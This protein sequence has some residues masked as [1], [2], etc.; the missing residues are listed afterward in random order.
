MTPPGTAVPGYD[1]VLG[2]PAVPIF[3]S[4]VLVNKIGDRHRGAPR[5]RRSGCVDGAPRLSHNSQ[6]SRES[7]GRSE[8]IRYDVFQTVLRVFLI[9]ESLL[10]YLLGYSARRVPVPPPST[11]F[12]TRVI[13]RRPELASFFFKKKRGAS[14]VRSLRIRNWWTIH[15]GRAVWAGHGGA[16]RGGHGGVGGAGRGYHRTVEG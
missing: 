10:K 16:R 7:C 1:V 11:K 4:F 6:N 8:R 14:R 13:S 9:S 5:R 3:F 15:D 2:Y 12:S